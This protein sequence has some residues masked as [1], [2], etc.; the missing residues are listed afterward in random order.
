MATFEEVFNAEHD[1]I[2]ELNDVKT[3]KGTGER[4]GQAIFPK[5]RGVGL[6]FSGGGIRSATFNLGI[7]QGLAS[8]KLLS[9]IHYL[10]TVSG[11]GYIGSWLI[12]W[13]KRAGGVTKVEDQLGN[14]DVHYIG[15]K[16][17]T[18][19]PEQVSFLRD[20]SNYMTP[21][22][23]L[24]GADTWAGIATYLRNVILNQ[25]I[26]IGILGGVV[27]LPWAILTACK[28]L[29][30]RTLTACSAN[31]KGL[32]LLACQ[33]STHVNR[34]CLAE[35][36]AACAAI[37][38][39]SAVCWASSQCARSSFTR[40]NPPPNSSQGG[41]LLFAILPLFVSA[42]LTMFALWLAPGCELDK[43]SL[44]CWSLGG[45][46]PYGLAH[47][48]G[49]GFRWASVS[50]LG[51][52]YPRPESEPAPALTGFQVTL[53]P[54]FAL[55]AGAVGGILLSLLN[56]LFIYW[57]FC[58]RGFPH[59]LT[60]GP[61]L[62]VSM[63]LLV[64]A[65]HIGLLKILIQNE[66]QEWWG[67]AGG[68]L[69]IISIAWTALFALTIFVPWLFAIQGRWIKTKTVALIG[70]AVTTAFGVISGKSAK[71]SGKGDGK[72]AFE[73]VAL[74]SPYIFVAG[75]MILLS[76]GAFEVAKNKTEFPNK[77]MLCDIA[78]S[79]PVVAKNFGISPHVDES[80]A[81][82]G[83]LA[84]SGRV[85]AEPAGAATTSEDVEKAERR[86]WRDIEG[87]STQR[88]ALLILVLFAIAG[89]LACRV[90]INLFSMNLLY[91][92]RL[93]RCYLGA[94]RRDCM[95]KPLTCIGRRPNPFT[96]FDPS[97]DTPLA[98]FRRRRTAA[99]P[100]NL[101]NDSH[102]PQQ[103]G[104]DPTVNV[105]LAVAEQP[106]VGPYPILCGALNVTHGERLAWQ[107]RKA[108]SFTF[109]PLFCGYEFVQMHSD[110]GGY[111]PT[112]KYAYSMDKQD[113]SHP[114]IGGVRLGTAMSISGAAA[115]PNMGFHTSP[116]LAF[117]MTMFDVR[118][119]WWLANSRYRDDE[120]KGVLHLKLKGAPRCSLYYLLSELFAS[121]TDRSRFVYLSDGG[122]FENLAVYELIRR[123]CK[124]IIACD[125]DADVDIQ[126]GDLGNMIRKCRSDLGVE[127]TLEN[128][129]LL[130]PHKT[131]T[132]AALHAIVGTIQ[133]PKRP[134]NPEDPEPNEDDDQGKILY[135][136]PT[137][138]K[139]LPRDI[140]AYSDTNPPFPYQTTA[141]QWFDESQFESYRRLGQFTMDQLAQVQDPK[142]ANTKLNPVKSI[143]DLFTHAETIMNDAKSKNRMNP[144]VSANNPAN[145]PAG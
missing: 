143:A 6:A 145:S 100:D 10:S 86:F 94:S 128:A 24:F 93:V 51:S 76:W 25:L 92:N 108:E 79:G 27:L 22:L 107:E 96:G 45:A 47:A 132:F 3:S 65:L 77:C 36:L 57:K 78:K 124:F 9:Q 55:V 60:W 64:G 89:L 40:V 38:M 81:N 50:S 84:A 5:P 29:A 125:G 73:I 114:D 35:L 75:L 15:K 113:P 26:L 123:R 111:Q 43:W 66:E 130:K 133:Y 32:G 122:H 87:L 16:G 42:L 31:A 14:Y 95:G 136:K 33:F 4:Q 80:T 85:V 72:P 61:I 140:L 17:I 13:I 68:L 115:S 54:S 144:P 110:N 90:D 112:E 2:P 12:S 134:K 137:I 62:L 46:V 99:G 106:Y 39:I 69:L 101:D 37:L 20:Y 141:D 8:A 67:R 120:L 102:P 127:I 104:Q 59:A 41:V 103:F 97:D 129:A 121:T 21:R 126:F 116:P 70:W 11:G 63:F 7:L 19:E 1:E 91:R 58:G 117:L 82:G 18:A 109:S 34:D 53:I 98:L 56:K 71:T 74:V 135:I 138:T 23:G 49:V 88:I 44:W 52:S 139:D 118:L 119:G 131:T 83:F 28:V 142:A 105:N 48:L 30:P